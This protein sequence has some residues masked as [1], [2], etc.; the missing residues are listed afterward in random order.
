[1][2]KNAENN[3]ELKGLDVD[4]LVMEHMQVNKAPKM[5]GRTYRAHGQVDAPRH[6]PCHTEISSLQK[7]RLFLSQKRRLHRK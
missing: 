3:A 4:S 7:S 2:L 5:Q 6:S 1:M